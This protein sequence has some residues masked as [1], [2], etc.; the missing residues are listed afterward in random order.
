[1]VEG[2]LKNLPLSNVCQILATG[3]KSGILT[4]SNQDKR[5]RLYF[6]MGKIQ[7]AH[8]T[9]GVHLGEV[10]VRMELLTSYEVQH[11]LLKQKRENA[12]TPLGLTAVAL[13][14]LEQD[15]LKQALHSQ[16]CEVLTELM[17][18]RRGDFHFAERFPGDSQVPT[19]HSFDTMM[20]LM[21]VIGRM[22]NL[23]RGYVAPDAIFK[24][25]GDPTTVELPEG[26]W[27]VLG[28]VDGQR[29]AISIAVE[30]DIS[31]SQV[32]HLLYVLEELE[33]IE[34][35]PYQLDHPTILVVSHSSA[36]LRLLRLS[37]WR[38]GL[39]PHLVGSYAASLE[40]LDEEHPKA[41]V[42]DEY[43]DEGWD[44][45]RSVRK[46][47]GRGH[48]PIVLLSESFK[49]SSFLE[50]LTRPKAH[51]LAKPF[52]E[53]AFQQLILQLAGKALT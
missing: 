4:V 29:S 37:L 16:I 5:A 26:A 46:L 53:I 49:I 8:I 9:P 48:I 45:V 15:D 50:R 23:K 3:M 17:L 28:H 42:V 40:Y 47:P 51:V 52:E 7:Y 18:W 36:M 41:I 38:A 6:E 30:L 14:Y 34:A 1:M 35:A 31:E 19:E 33:L 12:G 25:V 22:D 39:R 24:R 2:S 43:E 20:L 11:I 44:F 32:Y 21:E 27:D 13:A 10:L